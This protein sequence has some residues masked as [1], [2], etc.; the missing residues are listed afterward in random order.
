M[1]LP[2]DNAPVL[3]SLGSSLFKGAENLGAYSTAL[4]SCDFWLNTYIRPCRRRSKNLGPL[5][6]LSTS[7]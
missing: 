7:V 6:A 4:T 3:V 5:K 1:R 2:H